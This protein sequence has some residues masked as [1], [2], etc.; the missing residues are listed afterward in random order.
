MSMEIDLSTIL[1]AVC[2][3]TY[4]DVAPAETVTPY[5]TW[6]GIGGETLY[7]VDNTP[8][9]KRN[10]FL[11][12]SVWSKTRLEALQVIRQV[13]AALTSAAAFTATPEGEPMS[14]YENDT[15]LYGSIQRFDIWASR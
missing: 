7:Y 1:R 15:K 12:I 10:P 9:D 4:P 6:Q 8:A 14:T 11:Q 5:I 2:P 3:R 13:E